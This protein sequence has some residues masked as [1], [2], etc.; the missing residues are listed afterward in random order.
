MIYWTSSDLKFCSCKDSIKMKR[1]AGRQTGRQ[2]LKT[3]YL[4]K[5]WHSEYITIFQTIQ[6]KN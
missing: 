3:T 2:Y 1:Q 4:R 6:L 5:D